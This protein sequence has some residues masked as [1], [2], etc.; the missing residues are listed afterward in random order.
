MSTFPLKV[1]QPQKAA[2]RVNQKVTCD[3]YTGVAFTVASKCHDAHGGVEY[4]IKNT[5]T[6][7]LRSGLRGKYLNKA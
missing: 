3:Y 2:F 1:N 4:T 7:E 5:L 6:G